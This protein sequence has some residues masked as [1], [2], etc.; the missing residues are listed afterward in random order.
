M[1]IRQSYKC[2]RIALGM[3]QREFAAIAGVDE[4]IIS[5]FEGGGFVPPIEYAKVKTNVETY[6]RSLDRER[7]LTTRI[8]EETLSFNQTTD[9]TEKHKILAH[10]M[11]HVSKLNMDMVN[12]RNKE[13]V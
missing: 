7:Y 10:L 6:I 13:E 11:V 12:P 9:E 2:K 1:E 8:I 3:T 4:G 5:I